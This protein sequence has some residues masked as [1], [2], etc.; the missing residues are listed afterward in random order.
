MSQCAPSRSSGTAPSSGAA[1]FGVA[2]ATTGGRV[3]RDT[4]F[5]AASMSKPV[6]AYLVMKLHERG[7]LNLDTPLQEV[8]TGSL[9]RR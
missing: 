4:V 3:D 6:F 7:I 9:S 1:G 2:D 5:E 8:H